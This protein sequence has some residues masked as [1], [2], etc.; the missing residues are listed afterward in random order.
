MASGC[1]RDGERAGSNWYFYYF[2]CIRSARLQLLLFITVES[3]SLHGDHRWN[4]L[5]CVAPL[6]PLPLPLP[7]PSVPPAPHSS[8]HAANPP[9]PIYLLFFL[10]LWGASSLSPLS[11]RKMI[12]H[13]LSAASFLHKLHKFIYSS[14]GHLARI[15][16]G[17]QLETSCLPWLYFRCFALL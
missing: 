13:V 2:L 11:E 6:S 14:G 17:G 12:S 10:L 1:V 16:S 15:N 9:P 3:P 5:D 4:N 7:V 8:F